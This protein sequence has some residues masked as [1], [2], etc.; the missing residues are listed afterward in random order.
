MIEHWQSLLGKQFWHFQKSGDSARALAAC[1]KELGLPEQVVKK[2][3]G[4]K[5][6]GY[7]EAELQDVAIWKAEP[8]VMFYSM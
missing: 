5:W 4:K 6:I 7:A 8:L 1:T 2:G 3:S